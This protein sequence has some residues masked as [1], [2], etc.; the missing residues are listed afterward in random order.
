[1]LGEG[2]SGDG[3]TV[4]LSATTDCMPACYTSGQSKKP[5]ITRRGSPLAAARALAEADTPRHCG[6]QPEAT[7]GHPFSVSVVDAAGGSTPPWVQSYKHGRDVY[8]QGK[9]PVNT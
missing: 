5:S 6:I 4:P 1:M 2:R 9:R 8:H 3:F 7:V